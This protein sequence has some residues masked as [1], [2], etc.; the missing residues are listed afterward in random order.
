MERYVSSLFMDILCLLLRWEKYF[1]V[2]G[3]F[4]AEL[5]IHKPLF[6]HTLKILLQFIY[7]GG[8]KAEEKKGKGYGKDRESKIE[9]ET[10]RDQSDIHWLTSQMPIGSPSQKWELVTKFWSPMW[11]T[12]NQLFESLPTA[13]WHTISHKR[14]QEW[15]K[16]P[17]EALQ[18]GTQTS[19]VV[20]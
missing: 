6:T 19:Q 5:W 13:S 12:K 17:T 1:K 16:A 3:G 14:N 7:L 15:N 20:P 4:V 10:E 9:R 8:R 2:G 11:V 18:C